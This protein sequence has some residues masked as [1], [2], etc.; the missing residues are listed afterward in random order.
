MFSFLRGKLVFCSAGSAVLDVNGVGYALTVSATTYASLC[1]VRQ[2]AETKLLCHL[3]VREDGVELFGFYTE[4]ELALFRL[5]IS[6]SGIG[7]KAALSLLGTLSPGEFIAAVCTSK[8][9]AL[10]AAPGIGPKTAAR[11]ILELK[12]KLTDMYSGE[13][14]AEEL[15]LPKTVPSAKLSDAEEALSVLGY[16]KAQIQS[17]LKDIDTDKNDVEG[18][19]RIALQKFMR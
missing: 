19:I 9:K 14:T 17:V 15:P 3:A 18:I 4:E 16:T 11:I 12:D 6:V 7:P 13:D 10:S 1:R 2:D 8:N 5:L